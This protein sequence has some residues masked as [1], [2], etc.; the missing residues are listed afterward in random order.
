MDRDGRPRH[1]WI[2]QHPP[3]WWPENEPWPPVGRLHHR[4]RRRMPFF[5]FGC[6]FPLAFLSFGFACAGLLL[7]SVL[8]P[9]VTV[10]FHRLGLVFFGFLLLMVILIALGRILRRSVAPLGDLMDAADRVA[11][12]DYSARMAEQG[13]REVR[14]FTRSFNTMTSR[15]Q[16][17]DE[18]RKRLLADISHELRTPLTVLQ[19]NLEGMLDG[20]YPRDDGRLKTLLEE[21][22]VLS[23]LIEDLRTFSLAETG[24][25]VLEKEPCNPVRLIHDLIRAMQA[26]AEKAGVALVEELEPDL[27]AVEL[28]ATR[29]REVL[30]N[31]V[32]NA[33]RYTS[34]G[35]SVRVA[36]R[37]EPDGRTGVE[38]TVADNGR[39]I[40]AEDLPHVFD[41][42]FKSRDS[43]GIGL[44]LAIAKRLVE[45]HGGMIEARANPG[46][47]TVVQFGLPIQTPD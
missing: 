20:V 11:A 44:G 2:D 1:R 14:E 35:G 30:E 43:G 36:C 21:T 31:L 22:R 32:S 34:T 27:P 25:L 29:I 15:L 46:G 9:T 19:G 23:R 13:S 10:D 3:P 18:Q 37:R 4:Y 28:D 12:G 38:F 8:Q 7:L 33:L 40:A 41:R 16:A 17:Y 24:Q 42:Y 47:G 5:P 6:L 45:A 26:Q 39:G